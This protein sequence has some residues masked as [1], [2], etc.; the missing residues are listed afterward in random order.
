MYSRSFCSSSSYS[1]SLYDVL[2]FRELPGC[3]TCVDRLIY[4]SWDVPPDRH[5]SMFHYSREEASIRGQTWWTSSSARGQSRE[6]P[7]R[8]PDCNNEEMSYCS[9]QC[10]DVKATDPCQ[11]FSASFLFLGPTSSVVLT[12]GTGALGTAWSLSSLPLEFAKLPNCLCSYWESYPVTLK[13]LGT[14]WLPWRPT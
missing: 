9:T 10:F 3:F 1:G 11:E 6:N 13:P 8:F 2:F 7:G 12:S 5:F 14:V 4:G